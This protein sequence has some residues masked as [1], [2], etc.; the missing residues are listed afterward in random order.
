MIDDHLWK[1]NKY[2]F[3]ASGIGAL[4]AGAYK[5]YFAAQGVTVDTPL[6]PIVAL[7]M[8]CAGAYSA[9][10]MQS[11]VQTDYVDRLLPFFGFGVG[12]LTGGILASLEGIVGYSL[13]ATAGTLMR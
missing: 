11:P 3:I 13:G 5:G 1:I 4:A 8:T 9:T 7:H 2:A 12:A 6:E 10:L